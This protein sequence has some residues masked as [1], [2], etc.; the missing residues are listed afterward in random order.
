MTQKKKALGIYTI[1]ISSCL[2]LVIIGLFFFQLID[3]VLE[4]SQSQREESARI[5]SASSDP[6]VTVPQKN[7]VGETPQMI[8]SDPV[9]GAEYAAVTII[10]FGDF[11]CSDCAKMSTIIA[12]VV[13]KYP[14]DVQHVWKDFPIVSE[15]KHALEAAHAARCAQAQNAFWEYHDYLLTNQVSFPLLPWNDIA[16][17]VGLNTETF[18]QCMQKGEREYLV[19]QGRAAAQTLGLTVAPSYYIN[20]RFIEGVQSVEELSKIV[21]EEMNAK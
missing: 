2:F 20:D 15:H 4:K 19:T 7:G 18:S 21:E 13:K 10:E 6:L 17:S 8:A 12:E 1:G 5:E 14:N 11:Q 16:T 9:R 3:P